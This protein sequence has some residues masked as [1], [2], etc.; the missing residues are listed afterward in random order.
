M[1]YTPK[2]IRF[3]EKLDELIQREA[4]ELWEGNFSLAVRSIVRSHFLNKLSNKNE[5]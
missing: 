3:N 4:D 5:N 2:T 1:S